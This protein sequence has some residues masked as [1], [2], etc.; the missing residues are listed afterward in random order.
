MLV[1]G[2]RLLCLYLVVCLLAHVAT[3]N[4]LI[5]QTVPISLSTSSILQRK[6]SKLHVGRG[7]LMVCVHLAPLCQ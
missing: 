1:Y 6:V 3:A 2:C 5:H 7:L 4:P